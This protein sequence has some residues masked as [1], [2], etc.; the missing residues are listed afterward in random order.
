M[1]SFTG[2]FLDRGDCMSSQIGY[3][4]NALRM[5]RFLMGL[6]LVLGFILVEIG[7]AEIFLEKDSRCR[8]SIS[9]GRIVVDPYSLC[10]PEAGI[11]FLKALS[12]GPFSADSSEVPQ[13]F[14]W[15]L[16]GISYGVIGGFLAQFPRRTALLI[17]A[18]FHLIALISFTV[19]AYASTFIL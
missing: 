9:S 4:Q 3:S 15:I 11:F 10:T 8:D 13:T 6:F 2:S 14:A 1:R 19:I 12:R 17:F 5:M 16:M 7:I 18:V